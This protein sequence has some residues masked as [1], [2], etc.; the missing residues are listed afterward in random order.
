M[1]A[2]VIPGEKCVHGHHLVVVDMHLKVRKYRKKHQE[3]TP[4]VAQ[5]T[6]QD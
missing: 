4:G 2:K 1:N 6:T 3:K 5:G